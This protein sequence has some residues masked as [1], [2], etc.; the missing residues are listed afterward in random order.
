LD[1]KAGTVEVFIPVLD[2]KEARKTRSLLVFWDNLLGRR[3]RVCGRD[4]A[5]QYL[6]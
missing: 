1:L 3:L 4:E 5:G 6:V 2:E